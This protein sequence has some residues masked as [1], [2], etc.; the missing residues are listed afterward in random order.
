MSI[1]HDDN[2]KASGRL[3][4]KGNDTFQLIIDYVKQETLEPLKGLGRFVLFG[5]VGSVALAGGLVILAV[6]LL[7]VLQGETGT[8]FS[9]NLSWLPYVICAVATIGVGAAAVVAIG[10][11]QARRALE[12]DKET[13]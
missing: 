3:R 8:T 1:R 9:G 4:S 11:G 7:R 2:E 12:R 10:K 13:A 6:A 5:V